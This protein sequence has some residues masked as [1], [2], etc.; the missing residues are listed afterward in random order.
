MRNSYIVEKSPPPTGFC[1]DPICG[2]VAS[3][4]E[5]GRCNWV[6]CKCTGMLVGLSEREIEVL[7]LIAKGL[8]AGEV[9]SELGIELKTVESHRM[10]M[11]RKTGACKSIELVLTALRSGVIDPPKLDV[12][13]ARAV[14]KFHPAKLWNKPRYGDGLNP[15]EVLQVKAQRQKIRHGHSV[16]GFGHML[17]RCGTES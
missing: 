3:V 14:Q 6:N 5:K 8:S 11:F 15:R 16:P 10:N 9:A 13:V 1:E 4:H 17:N 2:H 12:R 7:E